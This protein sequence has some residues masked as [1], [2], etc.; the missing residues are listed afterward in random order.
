VDAPSRLEWFARQDPA[1]WGEDFWPQPYEQL[2]KVLRE[3]G[4]GEDARAVLIAKE[5]LQRAA[6]RRRELSPGWRRLLRARD[7]VLDKTIRFGQQP[8]RSFLWLGVFWAVGFYIFGLAATQDALKPSNPVVLRSA[9]WVLCGA[10][11]GETVRFGLEGQEVAGR[12][13]PG[14]SQRSCFREQPEAQSYPGFLAATY[15]LDTILPIASLQQQ[16]FWIPDETKPYGAFAR[17]YLWVHIALGWALSLLAVAGF[18]GLVK[19]D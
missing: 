10:Q 2:A 7:A 4:H 8:L 19:S 14:Q 5:R 18:S 1:P 11:A 6:R 16:E 12:A 15:S 13:E 9:E 3:M 17:G